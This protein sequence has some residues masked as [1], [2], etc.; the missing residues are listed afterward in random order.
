M[1]LNGNIGSISVD[2][3]FSTKTLHF[4]CV[5]EYQLKKS[6]KKLQEILKKEILPDYTNHSKKE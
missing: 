1:K 3:K 2:I 6:I 5:E 4:I